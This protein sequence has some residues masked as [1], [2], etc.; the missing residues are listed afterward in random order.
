MDGRFIVIEGV[1]GAGTTTQ[2][3]RL[4][5]TLRAHAVP[6]H[7]TQEPSGG[8]V[9]AMLRQAL[10]GRLVCNSGSGPRPPGWQTMALLFAADRLDHLDN[11][12]LPNLRDGVT[13]VCDRYD[14][15]SVGYQSRTSGQGDAAVPWIVEL[16]RHARR[17]DVVIV[18]DVP[19]D[20]A[21]KRRQERAAEEIFD[22]DDLQQ[23]LTAFYRD[24]EAHFPADHVVHIAGDG[25]VDQIA[26]LIWRQVAP[27]FGFTSED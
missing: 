24:L 4:V 7:R 8:P 19:F 12:V 9:G 5:Q 26:K 2:T 1:D 6:V 14:H 17:P 11:E 27:L 15:S 22:G 10:S 18:L 20:V 23:H 21:A 13:V 16:N 25:D 3:Q